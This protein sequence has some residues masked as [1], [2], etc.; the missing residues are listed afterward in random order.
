MRLGM[1]Y[2]EFLVAP[3]TAQAMVSFYENV[4]NAPGAVELED[5]KKVGRVRIGRNQS[6]A[7]RETNEP[8]A[9][10]DG[11]HIAVYVA[12]F[13][14]PYGFLKQRGLITEVVRNHQFRFKDIVDLDSG[15]AVF[16]LEHEV[17]S[18]H[19]PMF[20]RFFVNRDPTQLQRN[21]TRGRDAFIPFAR[22][23]DS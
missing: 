6:L 2:V 14:G 10:Y 23:T 11:H 20:Q 16:A 5:G 15:K 22:R 9:A 18:L 7:F 12:N 1:P 21:Y 19:H 13:S 8:L 17:R 4:L 3:H